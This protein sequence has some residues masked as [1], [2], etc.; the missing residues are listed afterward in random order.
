MGIPTR[1]LL[2]LA[3]GINDNE[4][5][6][7]IEF[8]GQN[9]FINNLWIRG[10]N[11]IGTCGISSDQEFITFDELVETVAEQ[12]RG[13]FTLN[14]VYYFQKIIYLLSALNNK[15]QCYFNQ[16]MIIPRNK[17]DRSGDW[18]RFERFS[19]ILDEFEKN[20]LE[21]ISYSKKYFLEKQIAIL[22]KDIN[23]LFCFFKKNYNSNGNFCS[24]RYFTLS[25]N[26]IPTLLN[27]N[28]KMAQQQCINGS[29]NLGPE[30]NAPRCY[31]ILDLQDN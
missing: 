24:P 10:Y 12:S 9:D 27:Y 20:Y 25:I 26:N 30:N 28:I 29:F 18:F 2:V 7:F 19:K 23:D 6:D 3:K 21:N 16:Y 22:S 17:K 1:I 4:I 13:L 14:D 8:V 31:E 11:D 5:S 15:P